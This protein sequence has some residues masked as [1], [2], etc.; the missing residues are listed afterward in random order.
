[1]AAQP[2]LMTVVSFLL[3]L[4]ILF[5][6]QTDAAPSPRRLE[7]AT[8]SLEETEKDSQSLEIMKHSGPS[9]SGPGHKAR[10]APSQG[11]PQGSSRCSERLRHFG[12][13]R[14]HH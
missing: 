10:D 8:F 14:M 11:C 1:M 13:S 7:L 9:P 3:L 2:R 4:S 6:P 5:V 12:F